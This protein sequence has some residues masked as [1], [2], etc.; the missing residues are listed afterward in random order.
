MLHGGGGGG[1]IIFRALFSFFRA[2]FIRHLANNLIVAQSMSYPNRQPTSLI[3]LMH[4]QIV[5][6]DTLNLQLN[7]T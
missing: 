2:F 4:F 5:K 1:G 3:A 7:T 6:M